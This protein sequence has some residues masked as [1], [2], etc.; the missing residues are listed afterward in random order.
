[1]DHLSVTFVIPAYNEIDGLPACWAEL[2]QFGDLLPAELQPWS[3]VIVDDGSTDG[4]GALLQDI[5][6]ADHRLKVVANS[7][8]LGSGSAIRRGFAAAGDADVV[9]Y[10]DADRPI[11]LHALLPALRSVAADQVDLVVGY[12]QDHTAD[13]PYRRVLSLGFNAL[14]AMVLRIQVRDINFAAKVISGRLLQS[15]QLT[16]EGSLIDAELIAR[17][18]RAGGRIQELGME[19]RPRTSGTSTLAT[20][21]AMIKILQELVP[22]TRELRR[23]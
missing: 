3:V 9:V 17:S 4:T 20:P 23:G 15:I 14:I 22:L 1:M 5:S 16:S 21:G 10:T 18:D 7:Q 13:G 6:C 19:Y 11:H 8:C 2:R 12:R